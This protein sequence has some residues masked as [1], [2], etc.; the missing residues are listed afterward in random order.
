MLGKTAL[1]LWPVGVALLAGAGLPFQAASNA[2]VGRAL[3]HPLWGAIASLVLSAMVILPLLGAQRAAAP[4]ISTALQGPWWLWVGGILGA[5]YVGGAAAVT[6]KLGAGGFLVCVVAGQMVMAVMVDHFGLMGI[7]P[8]PVTLQRMAGVA[9]ILGG[10]LI[11][12]L[13]SV[14]P[15][16]TRLGDESNTM[17]GSRLYYPTNV[18]ALQNETGN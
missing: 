1:S 4:T 6:P 9:L 14:K 10:V 12:H 5:V 16:A 8:K 11:V 7:A 18:K 15:P 13:A 2:A 17:A 3:G